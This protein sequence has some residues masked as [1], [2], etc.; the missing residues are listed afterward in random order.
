M[1]FLQLQLTTISYK[2]DQYD[3]NNDVYDYHK[4]NFDVANIEILNEIATKNR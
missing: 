1:L 4:C 2:K 3:E